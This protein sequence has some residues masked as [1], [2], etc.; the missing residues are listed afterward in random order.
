MLHEQ[1]IKETNRTGVFSLYASGAYDGLADGSVRFLSESV[2]Q[3]TL[4][5]LATRSAGDVVFLD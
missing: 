2:D 5:A 3:A 4:N 1:G